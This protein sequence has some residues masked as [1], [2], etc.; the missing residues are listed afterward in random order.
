MIGTR[1]VRLIEKHAD[2]LAIGLTEKLRQLELT[3]DFR[4]IP[5]E[6]LEITSA[7]LYRN[8][9]EWLLKKTEKDVEQHFVALAQRRAAEG[10]RLPQFVWAV[11][12]SRNHL[13][14]FLLRHAFADNIIELY[15]ELELQE[16]L[17][18]FFERAIYYGVTAYEKAR[19]RAEATAASARQIRHMGR[20]RKVFSHV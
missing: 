14:Q 9:G 7:E 18:Q 2:E 17:D 6:E 19:E 20:L 16:L 11:V 1:L 3:S 4:R 12:S 5:A 15:N 13:H 8:L 10:V